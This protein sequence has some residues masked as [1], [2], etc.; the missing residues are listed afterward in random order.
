MCPTPTG[1]IHTRTAVIWLPALFGLIVTLVTGHTDWIALV[2]VYYILGIFL[3]S[4]VYSWLF[5]FQPPW[6]TFVLAISELGLLLV[7]ANLLNDANGGLSHVSVGEA[8]IFY[9][10]CWILAIPITKVVLLPLISLTYLESAAEIRRIEWSIPEANL[11]LPVLA[12]AA[13]AN[14]GPGPLVREASGVHAK[15]LPNLPSPSGVHRQV[16]AGQAAAG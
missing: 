2:G 7:L 11:P 8:V 6:M 15:P 4:A 12:S 16:Q 14:R 10:I 9:W 13:E 3:D 5:R 1:R